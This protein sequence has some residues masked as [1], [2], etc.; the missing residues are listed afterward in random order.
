M[1]EE[2]RTSRYAQYAPTLLLKSLLSHENKVHHCLIRGK[3]LVSWARL[4]FFP[5]G[6][7]LLESS[8]RAASFVGTARATRYLEVLC[9]CPSGLEV[10]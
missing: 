10:A 6:F 7:L 9:L 1:S 4:E 8:S 3:G 2:T 5:R